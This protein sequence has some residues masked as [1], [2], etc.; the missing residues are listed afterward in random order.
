MPQEILREFNIVCQ[1][2]KSN[3]KELGVKS[4]ELYLSTELQSRS[5]EFSQL[6]K[7][8]YDSLREGALAPMPA[9][10]PKVRA[11]HEPTEFFEDEEGEDIDEGS[12]S[13]V[14]D[15]IPVPVP[16]K[17]PKKKKKKKK[18]RKSE[19]EAENSSAAPV[20]LLDFLGTGTAVS[21]T[22][23]NAASGT[24]DN[25]SSSVDLLADLFAATTPSTPAAATPTVNTGSSDPL[26]FLGMAPSP[27]PSP[28]AAAVPSPMAAAVP[29]PMAAAVPSPMAATAPSE[30]ID[31]LDFGSAPAP[32]ASPAFT[33]MQ[34]YSG[35]GLTI[36][37]TLD[38]DLNDSTKTFIATFS[39]SNDD[40]IENLE[41]KAAVPKV[42]IWFGGNETCKCC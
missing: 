16:T 39:N 13:E 35:D 42:S 14:E 24:A 12:D 30:G 32:V 33:P 2:F 7:E 25:D 3:K 15:V 26:D 31:L 40:A 36:M 27:S 10:D 17:S 4:L 21:S 8:K 37:L 11:R 18:S 20:D 9:V 19:P 28:M 5:C 23:D 34:I 41:F 1:L 38:G 6:I 29:S 22:T